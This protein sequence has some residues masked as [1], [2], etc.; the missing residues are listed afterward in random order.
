VRALLARRDGTVVAMQEVDGGT[1]PAVVLSPAGARLATF[2]AADAAGAPLFSGSARPWALAESLEGEVWVTGQTGPVIFGPGGAFVRL[3][4]PLP[5]PTRG[6]APLAD[7]RMLVSY[8]V[9]EIALYAPD[10]TLS[11]RL[12]PALGVQAVQGID[13]LLALADGT[14]LV[15]VTRADLTTDGAVVPARLE[16][17]RLVATRDPA[18]SARLP[19][20]LPSAL[21]V[22][23]DTVVAAPGLGLLARPGCVERLT[24]DLSTRLGCLAPGGAQRGVAFLA[25]VPSPAR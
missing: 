23:G 21:A 1:A 18:L 10:G 22:G 20:W 25:A 24:L 7:G 5:Y 11:E 9:Q 12:E 15:A 19:G 4:E 8:G 2:A 6:I 17:G 13:A 16:A 14:I 3:A